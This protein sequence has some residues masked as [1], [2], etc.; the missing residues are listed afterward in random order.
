MVLPQIELAEE[1]IDHV[2]TVRRD[3]IAIE[4]EGFVELIFVVNGADI[5][6]DILLV[7][8]FNLFVGGFLRPNADFVEDRAV[9]IFIDGALQIAG[10]EAL[11]ED[12]GIPFLQKLELTRMEGENQTV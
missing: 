7:I 12:G 6:D 4:G 1:R 11:D 10:R 5:D 8:S 2:G 9:E 3:G